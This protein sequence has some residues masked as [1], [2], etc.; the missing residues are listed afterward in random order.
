MLHL[1]ISVKLVNAHS[2]MTNTTLNQFSKCPDL[3]FTTFLLVSCS[4]ISKYIIYPEKLNLRFAF[5]NKSEN[6]TLVRKGLL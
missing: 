1:M 6:K 3:K 4:Y 2:Y 5:P